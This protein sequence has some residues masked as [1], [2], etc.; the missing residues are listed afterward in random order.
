MNYSGANGSSFS[1]LHLRSLLLAQGTSPTH[2]LSN[3][4]VENC[5]MARIIAPV[6]TS[7]SV[8]NLIVRNS[9]FNSSNSTG[10]GQ[11]FEL[12]TTSGVIIS[13]NI[14]RGECCVHGS[15]EGD[16]LTIQNNLFFD[17]SSSGIAFMQNNNCV[18]QNN[19]FLNTTPGI[20]AGSGNS[21]MN[22]ISYNT[23]DDVFG[24]GSNGNTGSG[25]IEATDPTLT[26]LPLTGADNDW[27]YS[28]D[29]TPLAGS[30]VLNAGSDGTDIGPSGGANPFDAEGTFLPLI[31]SLTVPAIVTQGADLNVNIKAK[32]N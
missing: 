19:I 26:N 29:I 4:L 3:I 10:D 24:V 9:I 25:N 20:G 2:T 18:I 32:G 11:A 8:G 1:G 21:F 30:P 7:N 12:G 13:N 22:N 5:E 6:S 15:I 27:N 14:I 16:N 31:E 17:N 28:Y 23:S